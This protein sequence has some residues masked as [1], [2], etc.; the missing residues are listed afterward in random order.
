MLNYIDLF[1]F[2]TCFG[3]QPTNSERRTCPDG[4]N[5][6]CGKGPKRQRISV[7]RETLDTAFRRLTEAASLTGR[8]FAG[9]VIR[10]AGRRVA[11]RST[12]Q[13]ACGLRRGAAA[14]RGGA[15]GLGHQ[16]GLPRT[17]EQR[18]LGVPE[19]LAKAQGKERRSW[20]DSG[21]E[22]GQSGLSARS[23]A[24]WCEGRFSSHQMERA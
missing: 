21:W 16:V 10:L 2:C 1:T 8:C 14:L 5:T 9:C 24:C 19:G 7:V 23:A 22:A 13:P 17:G 4:Q 6:G 12:P 15:L 3:H 18:A 20:G 11:R